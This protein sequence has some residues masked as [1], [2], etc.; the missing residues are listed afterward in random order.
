[1]PSEETQFKKGHKSLYTGGSKNGHFV[2]EETKKKIGK[3]NKGRKMS[4]EN[5]EKMRLF[6][7]GKKQS[8]ETVAKR[9]LKNKGQKRTIEFRK[10]MSELRKG[11]KSNLWKGGVTE[12]NKIIRDEIDFR[13]GEKQYLKEIILYAKSAGKKE[14]NCILIILKTFLN[15]QS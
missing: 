9:I 15:I 2:S 1:M 13:F 3:A 14:E 6:H 5:I 8:P 4:V 12:V 11:N 7:I 10:F